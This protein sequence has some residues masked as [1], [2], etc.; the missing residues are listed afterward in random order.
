MRMRATAGLM[1]LLA[2]ALSGHAQGKDLKPEPDSVLADMRAGFVTAGGL[3]FDIGITTSTFIN[4]SLAL[5]TSVA[6]SPTAPTGPTSP[7][8]PT[9]PTSPTAPTAP[10][11]SGAAA[12]VLPV[13][14]PAASSAST[15]PP[16]AGPSPA[17]GS[18]APPASSNPPAQVASVAPTSVTNAAP[19]QPAPAQSAPGQIAS[20]QAGSTQAPAAQAPATQTASAQS[21]P[22]QSQGQPQVVPVGSQPSAGQTVTASTSDGQTMV[23]Q[24]PGQL[25]NVVTN[26]ANGQDIRLNTVVNVVLPGFDAVQRGQLLSGMGMKMGADGSFGIVSSLSH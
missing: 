4:G 8:A 1:A 15:S 12:S 22:T 24:N 2:G 3:T 21:T 17:A 18:G 7:T 10:T 25:V 13:A 26:S 14:A 23:I 16:V 19:A 9:T 5:T 20:T 6:T 11:G